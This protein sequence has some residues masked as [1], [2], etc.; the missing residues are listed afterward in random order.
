MVDFDEVIF[1]IIPKEMKIF[2]WDNVIKC[3]FVT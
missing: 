2:N 3:K 1:A